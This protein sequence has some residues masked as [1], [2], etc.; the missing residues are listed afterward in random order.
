MIKKSLLFRLV[1]LMTVMMCAFGASAQYAYA[2][3]TSDNTTLTFYFDYERYNRPGAIYDLTDEAVD[4]GW[5][6]DRTNVNVKQVVFDPSFADARRMSTFHWFYEMRNLESIIGIYNLNTSKV[7]RMDGM[8]YRCYKLTVLNLVSFNTSK[9]TDMSEMFRGCSALQT[10]YVGQGWSMSDMALNFSRNVFK[11]CTSLVGGQGTTYD[12]DHVDADYAHVDGG[13][14]NPG[15]LSDVVPEAYAVYTWENTTLS[16]YYDGYRNNRPGTIYDLNTGDTDTGWDTDN[17]KYYVTQVVFDPSFAGARPTTTYDW[18]NEMM[19]L[20][21]ITG[22][23][24]LNTSEVTNMAFMF[25]NCEKLASVDVSHFNTSQVTSLRGMFHFNKVLTSLDMSSFNTSQVTDMTDMFVACRKLQTIYVGSGWTTDAVDD[26]RD[27]FFNCYSLVGGQGTTYYD[28]NPT[29]KTYAH[30]DG[31]PSDPG[32]FT[33]GTEAYAV[34]TPE[35][36]TLTFYYDQLRSTREGT[37]YDLN[38]AGTHTGWYTDGITTS[39]TQVVFDPSFANARPT[40]TYDWFHN[41]W[42]IESITGLEYL[43]TSEVTDMGYMFMNCIDLTSLDLSRFNT[44]KVT[45]MSR[46]FT[47]CTSL[48]SLDLSSFNTSQVTNMYRMFANNVHLQTIYV[49]SGWSTDGVTVSS[50]DMFYG[51]TNLV[52]GQGTTYD[53]GHVDATYAHIDGGFRNPGYFTEKPAFIRG[54][55][56]G[57]GSVNISDVT[58]LIDLLLGGGTINNPA[59]DCNNDTNVTISDVTALIDYLLSGTW[60]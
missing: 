44:S 10:I 55:V 49:S 8:F 6:T 21:S 42:S 5:V 53:T 7:M 36:S 9:V 48:N 46:M 2:V 40:S 16:F 38:I 3:Y 20:E 23:E 22:L 27:M 13:T 37:T 34:Y 58:A 43:N 1:V 14:G 33:L 28:S 29:D 11:D 18:F 35:N 57:D 60:N 26:S 25:C 15:Y 4:P 51:C 32:Y 39:V 59:A 30:V 50:E 54:D 41:M 47:S 45:N 19:N 31:G 12:A 24:Y 56:N 17:T 52:G